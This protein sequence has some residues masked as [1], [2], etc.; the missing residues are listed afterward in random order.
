TLREHD[1]M[2]V[3]SKLTRSDGAAWVLTA[4]FRAELDININ[5]G[6]L[7]E[8]V[9]EGDMNNKLT[10][11]QPKVPGV[12]G[13]VSPALA[14]ERVVTAGSLVRLLSPFGALKLRVLVTDRVKEN[15]LDL[16]MNSTDNEKAINFLTV[17]AVDTLTNTPAYKQT[18]VR[19]EVLE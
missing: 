9:H 12:F 5:T 17:P 13:E 7:R 2:N 19:M 14:K 15:A 3:T 18:K 10:G 16:P 8:H 1:G 11:M 4:Q 6:V